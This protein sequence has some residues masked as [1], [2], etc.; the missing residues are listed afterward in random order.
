ML[1]QQAPVETDDME[2]NILTKFAFKYIQ[3]CKYELLLVEQCM[4]FQWPLLVPYDI[5]YSE[6]NTTLVSLCKEIC[7][8]ASSCT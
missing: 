1:T 8:S 3:A 5:T 4:M 6:Y 7:C 2:D